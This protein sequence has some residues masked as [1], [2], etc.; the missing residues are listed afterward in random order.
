MMT[1]KGIFGLAATRYSAL[2]EHGVLDETSLKSAEEAASA[3][4]VD[5]ETVLAVEHHIHK[6]A[7]LNALSEYYRL[8]YIEYDERIPVPP[9]LP[10]GIDGEALSFSHWFP[11]IRHGETIVVAA[12]NPDDPAAAAEFE[13]YFK[14]FKREVRV[15]L[16]DDIA[17][18]IKDYLHSKPGHYVGTERTGF[19][20]WRNTMAH[21]RTRLACYRTNLASA[22]TGLA[23]LRGGLGMVAI[24][25]A[26][27]RAG[28]YSVHPIL[29]SILFAGGLALASYGF[30]GYLKIR[31]SNLRPP[32]HQTTIEVTAATLRFLEDYHFIETGVEKGTRETMLG[33]LGDFIENY[34][35]YLCPSPA[36]KERTCLARERN[37]LAAQRTVAAAYRTIYARA[38]TGLAF[39]RTGVAFTSIGLGFMGY[40]G[41]SLV[42]ILDSLLIG[43]GLLMA[44][45][46][47][48]WYLPVRKEQAELPRCL[49]D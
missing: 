23:A 15:A 14:G 37:V 18:F 2:V 5:I 31:R 29:C 17:W 9:E 27:M 40:F 34:S 36:S 26:L 42:T 3:R 45:D 21:W 28:T 16:K 30:V 22:R 20:F 4:G 25:D 19:A 13:R 33:R 49:L 12:N 7:L 8:P 44:V 32:G 39:I 24:S 10:A 41:L 46:G 11:V 35:T 1:F 47:A 48:L 6:R 43:T 38:R